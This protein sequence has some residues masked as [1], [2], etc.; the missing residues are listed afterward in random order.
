M[1]VETSAIVAILLNEP[2]HDQFVAEISAA[3]SR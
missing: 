1:L 2:E 3:L